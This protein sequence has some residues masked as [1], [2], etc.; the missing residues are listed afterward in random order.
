MALLKGGEVHMNEA[1][2]L[3]NGYRKYRGEA[4]DVYFNTAI[5]AHSGNCVR[6]NPEIFDLQRKP[7]IQP[8][9][10]TKVEVMRV[11]QTCPSG[12]LKC[13]EK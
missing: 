6:G 4:V 8:D 3:K 10:E 13:I 2:L 11:I 1:Q 5:C 12:A 9:N 7:W